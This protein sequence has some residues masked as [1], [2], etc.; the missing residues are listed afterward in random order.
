MDCRLQCWAGVNPAATLNELP[1]NIVR[2]SS[3]PYTLRRAPKAI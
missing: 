2:R 3:N 1:P